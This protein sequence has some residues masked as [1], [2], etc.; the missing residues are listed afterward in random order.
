MRPTSVTV[1]TSAAT[2]QSA[3]IPVDYTQANFNLGIMVDVTAGTPSWVVQ[4]TMDDPFDPAVTPTAVA[5][6]APLET[7][8]TDEVG[9]ITIP[10][11]A[12]RLYHASSSGTS[13]MTVIQGRK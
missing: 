2:G 6:A 8:T 12:V 13:V 1:T 3:W 7:G 5:A 4:I 10:C 9:N 11:R